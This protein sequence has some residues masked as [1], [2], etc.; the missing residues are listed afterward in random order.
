MSL[1]TRGESTGAGLTNYEGLN[2]GESLSR[3]DHWGDQALEHQAL[4]VGFLNIQNFPSH[5]LHHKNVSIIQVMK[6]YHLN[7]LGLAELNI[8]CHLLITQQQ[9]QERTRGWFS[10]IVSA[11]D[12]N[13]HNT[14]IKN[15][16]GGAVIIARD[17]LAHRCVLRE[18]DKLDRWTVMTF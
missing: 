3:A 11:A 5:E 17:Q 7:C 10:F 18:Y 12:Y 15:Q 13:K 9:I 16:Q 6:N 4:Q 2:I 14:M 8:Y 1:F